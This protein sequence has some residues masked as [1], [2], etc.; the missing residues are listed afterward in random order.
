MR[1][2]VS[3]TARSGFRNLLDALETPLPAG[4]PRRIAVEPGQYRAP[5]YRYWNTLEIVAVR[6]P[7]SVVLDCADDYLLQ[8]EGQVT[9]RGLVLRNWNDNGT[10]VN[11][12]GG[13]LAAEDC[14]FVAASD[15]AIS[16]WNGAELFVRRGTVRDGAIVLSD[17][18]GIV[19]NTLVTDARLC[20]VALHSGSRVTLRDVL[21]RNA[22]EHGFWVNTGSAPLLDQCVVEDAA[23]GGVVIQNRSAVTVRGGAVRRSGQGGLVVRENSTATAEGVVIEGAGGFGVLVTD[24][25]RLTAR[26]LAVRDAKLAGVMVDGGGT[27]EFESCD[28]SGA[29]QQGVTV[30]EASGCVFTGGSLT[31]CDLGAGVA[32]DGASLTLVGTRVSGNTVAGTAA[33]PGTRM[34]LRDCTITGNEGAGILASAEARLEVAGTT[35][36]ADNGAPDDLAVRVRV[37][38]EGGPV[39]QAP[40]KTSPASG[41]AAASGA[42]EGPLD[43]DALLA[44][45]DAMIGLREVK[46]EIHK[47]VKFLRI[48]EQR[49]RAGLPEGP[50]IGRH[51]VFS[52]SPGTGKTTVARLYGRLLAALGAV[53]GDRFVEASRSDLVG[54]VLG[55]TTQKTTAVF[56]SARGGVLFVDEAYALA[57]RFGIG[58]DFGQEAIDTLVKL[59]ED[60]RDEVAVVF[61]G[62]SAEMREFLSANPGLE[63]RVSRT[64]EFED[65]S[66][67]EL[68][69]I[70]RRMAGG[71]G[72]RLADETGRVLLEHF[73]RARRDEHFGNG[74]EARRIF[75]AALGQ[76][77]L[78]LAD[79]AEPP[80]ADDLVLLLPEDLEGVVERGLGV[81]AGEAR[82]GGQVESV[83]ARLDA[84]IGLEPVKQRVRDVLDLI[85]T[86]L[87]RERAGL[88]AEPVSGHLVFAGP[89][90][91]GKTTV[92]R[93][94]GELL[95]ALGF[96][97]RG[98]VVEVSRADLV[99][100]YVGHTAARTRAAFERARGGVLFVDEAYALARPAGTGHDFGQE[101]IDTLVKLMEDH[102]DE[103]VVIVAGYTAEM[104]GF[105]AANP[106]LASRF[107]MTVDFPPYEREELVSILVKQAGDA[108]FTV[109]D[110][111]LDAVRG[112][113]AAH[114]DAFDTGNGREV[115]KLFEAMRTA[116]ARR[117]ARTERAGERVPTAELGLLRRE[118]VP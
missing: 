73:R 67:A 60:H 102:R 88:P 19:E 104:A 33:D 41:G 80:S 95:A 85:E 84:M 6:G 71:Y 70:V 43:V 106:G 110:D 65:Y 114:A 51:V 118:D 9:L 44:E 57:R 7:G 17:A 115:R 105:L 116:H 63:S 40:P 20:G 22:G 16:A 39:G 37:D 28:V 1:L 92:A 45:L 36:S 64:I 21:V 68:T 108:G 30:A 89:P 100:E 10:V 53:P 26:G 12:T 27:A 59:M 113:L 90:G 32:G 55:E 4:V 5:S 76:Q 3:Q 2:V 50:V 91:T 56:E 54:K 99:G 42:G 79:A 62:Y 87:R 117:I 72:F 107:S 34:T 77:A 111:A 82:D 58:S 25:G 96:L 101:A 11:V 13:T 98:Q 75:E 94:Y 52:G 31:G 103:V 81:R 8:V 46:Q 78:R 35:V 38:S 18:A 66:P 69:E 83:R 97:A 112:H 74:R 93:L 23:A 47:L 29:A 49:R 15:K 61:A 48:A 14:E 109:T 24:A 86:T